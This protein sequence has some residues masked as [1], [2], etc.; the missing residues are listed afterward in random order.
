[1]NQK[2]V[3]QAVQ[4]ITEQ[5]R[6][7]LHRGSCTTEALAMHADFCSQVITQ[8]HMMRNIESFMTDISIALADKFTFE[9]DDRALVEMFS[10]GVV[11]SIQDI[12]NTGVVA[13]AASAQDAWKHVVATDSVA[14]VHIIMIVHRLHKTKTFRHLI[15]DEERLV[16][17]LTRTNDQEQGEL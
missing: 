11:V 8:I 17:T 6:T 4:E 9:E 10:N 13:I 7:H 16:K 2:L 14:A 1:M 12:R 5:L 3:N 15:R